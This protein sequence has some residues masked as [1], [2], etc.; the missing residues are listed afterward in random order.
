MTL[1]EKLRF[2]RTAERYTQETVAKTLNLNRSTY[3][4]YETGKTQPCIQTLLRLAKLYGVSVEALIS[5]EYIPLGAEEF[6]MSH[7]KRT[8]DRQDGPHSASGY[9]RKNVR[10]K[11]GTDG[12]KPNPDKK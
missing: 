12:D 7:E 9:H 11:S 6:L 2:Y 10:R 8:R 4:Y 1:G 5:E 3:T